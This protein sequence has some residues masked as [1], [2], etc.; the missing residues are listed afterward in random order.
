MPTLDLPLPLTSPL[1]E[2][3]GGFSDTFW[4]SDFEGGSGVAA[5]SALVLEMLSSDIWFLTF[6]STWSLSLMGTAKWSSPNYGH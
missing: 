2:A 1:S 5:S 6:S 4:A 3:L